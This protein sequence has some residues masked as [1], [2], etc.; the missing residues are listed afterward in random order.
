[1]LKT[2]KNIF[3]KAGIL[4][5][6]VL[7]TVLAGCGG[8]TKPQNDT[9]STVQ[10][11]PSSQQQNVSSQQET[12]SSKPQTVFQERI[13]DLP[14]AT[15]TEV[16]SD[17]DT[18][19]SASSKPEKED[20]KEE[21]WTPGV[22]PQKGAAVSETPLSNTYKLLTQEK[23]LTIGY[24]G[25]SITLGTSAQRVV[26]GGRVI[27]QAGGN[28]MDS[29]VNRV[30]TW[31]A[32]EYP[33]AKIETVNAGVSDTATNFG[34]FRLKDQLMNTN[35]HDMPD[36]VFIEFTNND[37]IYAPNQTIS[38][39]KLQIES[40]IRNIYTINPYAEIVAVSTNLY[41]LSSSLKAYT[42]MCEYYGIPL[43][44]VGQVLSDEMT[45]RG[46]PSESAGTFYY[47]T[48]NL[49]PSATGYY[50][51][52][53][54]IKSKL[55]KHLKFT[56]K[57]KKIFNYK[58]SLPTPKSSNLIDNPNILDI[59]SLNYSGN[60]SVV[61]QPVQFTIFGTSTTAMDNY[62]YG[63]DEYLSVGNGG[64]I[65]TT[66]KGTCLGVLL[67]LT[68]NNVDFKYK[69]DGGEWKTFGVNDSMNSGQRYEH[70]QIFMLEH[71]LSDT[72]H[73][74]EIEFTSTEKA[75]LGALFVNG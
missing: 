49:H 56:A 55:S 43:I 24:I 75:N 70:P 61:K 63:V 25:G 65:S 22:A 30:S 23:K 15:Y 20:S 7:V 34:V 6:A 42:E 26:Q 39:L 28:I 13:P 46:A 66:F 11:T 72:T 40:L 4:F 9:N 17:N 33:D 21:N 50:V 31:F 2:L 36:L 3:K 14:Y 62:K 68:R 67:V 73:T 10:S 71:H 5:M 64:K 52:T 57:S 29:W 51:Y 74:L 16:S 19:S 60:V 41:K 8:N 37:H 48:D 53:K 18:S 54:E 32:E 47:T 38:E 44:N 45:K 35:G 69:I 27:A 58:N 1:M 59:N 12:V